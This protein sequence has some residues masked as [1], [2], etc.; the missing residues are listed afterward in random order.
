M[1]SRISALKRRRA[2]TEESTESTWLEDKGERF[3]TRA[4]KL[5]RDAGISAHSFKYELEGAQFQCDLAVILD[6]VLFVFECKNYSLPHGQLVALYYY[7]RCLDEAATQVERIAHQFN[8]HSE[9]VRAH[10]GS[11][12]TWQCIVPCVLQALPWSAGRIGNVYFYD[13]SALSRFLE[14]GYTSIGSMT[15]RHGSHFMRRHKFLLR[16]A[17]IPTTQELVGEFENPHQ[18]RLSKLG[19]ETVVTAIPVSD[20]FVLGLPEWR[21]RPLTLEEQIRALSS[22]P[23]EAVRAA[24]ELT[25]GEVEVPVTEMGPDGQP[26]LP[27]PLPLP[28]RNEPC[29]CGSGK[30]F[31][32]CCL[33]RLS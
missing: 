25:H 11:N 28:G 22:S 19:W 30:K 14:E 27:N 16:K 32:K 24:K 29:V 3:E 17:K 8:Q 33:P 9:I 23:E 6:D 7:L 26:Q 15:K 18:L 2:E 13:N 21:Q 12:A 4:L 1:L 31:K 5:F 10:F 20:S